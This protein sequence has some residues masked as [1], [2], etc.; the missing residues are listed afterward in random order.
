MKKRLVTITEAMKILSYSNRN[1]IVSLLQHLTE[2][3]L[4][5]IERKNVKYGGNTHECQAFDL[6]LVLKLKPKL[7]ER[8]KKNGI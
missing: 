5:K 6:N 8:I 3:G 4:L 7:K 2:K 1:N